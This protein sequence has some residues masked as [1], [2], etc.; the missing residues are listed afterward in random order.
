M[1]LWMIRKMYKPHCCEIENDMQ[2]TMNFTTNAD[3]TKAENIS[4]FKMGSV[5]YDNS[6]NCMAFICFKYVSM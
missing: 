6:F 4:I 1:K 5:S 3:L 2:A